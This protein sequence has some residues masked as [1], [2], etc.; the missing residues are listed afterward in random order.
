MDLL[1][2]L[3]IPLLQEVSLLYYYLYV[4]GIFSGTPACHSDAINK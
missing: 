1:L 2:Y 3:Q 4:N